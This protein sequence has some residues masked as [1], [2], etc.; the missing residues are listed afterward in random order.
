MYAVWATWIDDCAFWGPFI[1]I[2]H[3]HLTKLSLGGDLWKHNLNFDSW[4]QFTNQ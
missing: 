2:V 3:P 1:K 4:S